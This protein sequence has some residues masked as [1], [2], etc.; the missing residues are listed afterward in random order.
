[1]GMDMDGP[2]NDK[3]LYALFPVQ[4]Q[5]EIRKENMIAW[6][7]FRGKLGG[8]L[9][10]GFMSQVSPAGQYVVTSI[11][12]PG[13][14]QSDYERRMDPK[15]LAANYYVANFKQYRFLQVFFPT[16]GSWPGTARPA[17]FC[18]RCPERTTRAT[19]TPP[20]RGVRTASTWYFSRAEARSAYSEGSQPAQA[21]NDP[22]ETQIQYDLYRIPFNEGGAAVPKPSRGLRGTG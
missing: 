18:S 1:M 3:G 9:R 19:C 17:G 16:R 14:G 15:D 13:L 6:S 10:V 5:T 8:K 2:K 11:N 22:N 20:P 4:P 21:A 7:T 12:D